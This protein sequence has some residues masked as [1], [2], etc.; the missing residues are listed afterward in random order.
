MSGFANREE[1]QGS[2]VAQR[3]RLG[4]EVE[5]ELENGENK[6]KLD[7]QR[8][9]LQQEL[10]DVEKLSFIPQ[11]IQKKRFKEGDAATVAGH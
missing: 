3:G 11:E 5:E 6:R 4:M 10:R 2:K 7:E 9:R 1:K 8:K